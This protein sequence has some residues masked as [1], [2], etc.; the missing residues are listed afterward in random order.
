MITDGERYLSFFDSVEKYKDLILDSERYI[1]EHPESGY[2]EWNTHKYMK[3]IFERFGYSVNE[4]GNI[5][6]FY[7]DIDTGREGPTFGIFAEMDALI[8]PNHP[9]CDKNTG[10]V[11][12]CAHHLQCAAM[13]GIA[14]ALSE[15][16][17]L[18]GMSGKIRLMTVSAEEP[19]ELEFRKKLADDGI[20]KYYCGKQELI[21]RGI[22][23][24]VD[25][26]MMVHSGA[27]ALALNGGCNGFVSKRMT[28][29]GKASH[30]ASPE[31]GLN[32]LY[33]ATNAISAANAVREIYSA[34]K[35]FRFH[36]IITKGGD[37]V[38]VIPSEVVVESFTRGADMK[39]IKA[40]NDRINRAFAASAA[41]LGC[42]L[43]IED[44]H[45]AAPRKE[46]KNLQAAVFEVG[47]LLFDE[48][49]IKD[50]TD[51]WSSGCTDMG[52]VS[53][54]MPVVHPFVGSGKMAGHSSTYYVQ[55]KVNGCVTNAKFQLAMVYYVMKDGAEYAK[56]VIS[57][58]DV[59]YHSKE[60]YIE[61]TQA[62][63]FFGD[64]VE[65]NDDGTLTIK[66]K[67]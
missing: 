5:P 25:L 22:L 61:A 15:Q 8:I 59:L 26:A 20:I 56:K 18:D 57:E 49:S 24:D 55:D 64:A 51:Q 13:I 62:T 37:A 30:G 45:G 44:R 36:P 27:A 42:R 31:R 47:K 60:E 38:N 3:E 10:A 1:W 67:V 12:A 46:D 65:Y 28:F 14:A 40:A 54:L 41:A 34:N 4:Y 7:V 32:A 35:H 53:T 33:A 6:G 66:Y 39:T 63:S 2:R 19:I 16:G 11:H 50:K 52:D 9:E 17:A 58:A 29:V 21:Y 23:D 48:K 43:V